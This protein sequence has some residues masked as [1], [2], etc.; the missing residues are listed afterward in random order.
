[1]AGIKLQDVSKDI[2]PRTKVLV[3]GVVDYSHIAS[4][5]DGDELKRANEYTNYPSKDPY[6]KMTVV[7]TKPDYKD[8]FEFDKN[9]KSELTLAAYLGSKVYQSNKEDKKGINYFS[10][11]SKGSEVRVYKLGADGKAHKVELN[12]NELA[13][14]SKVKLELNF[15]ETQYGAGVGLNS[16]LIL[17]D[18]I[19]V[20]EGNNSVKGYD[21]ANDTIALPKREFKVVDDVAAA[22]DANETP[23][24]DTSA[25]PGAVEVAEDPIGSTTAESN[26][27]FDDLLAQFKAG[28]N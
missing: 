1:M 11:I 6:Y 27:T 7:I 16:V 4:K 22:S 25:T 26:Q 8:A 17:D 14:G 10:A 24:T 15:F 21:V 28:N 19:K 12:G 13:Q 23:V 20:F 3:E 18:E 5:I 2:K 9:D